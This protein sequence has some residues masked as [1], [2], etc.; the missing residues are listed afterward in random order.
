MSAPFFHREFIKLRRH[1]HGKQVLDGL[2]PHEDTLKHLWRRDRFA[3]ET[4]LE[5]RSYLLKKRIDLII[6]D[7][8]SC[9]FFI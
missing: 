4:P 5:M 8:I 7:D 6:R 1:S 3:I 9:E 2:A